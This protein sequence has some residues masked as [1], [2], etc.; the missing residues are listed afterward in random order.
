VDNEAK[1]CLDEIALDL[2]K[3]ADAKAVLVGEDTTKEKAPPKG[4]RHAPVA[5][6]AAQRAVNTKEYLVTEKGI[7][8]SRVSVATGTTDGQTVEDYLVPAGATFTGDVSGT[9]P[10]DETTVKPV[11]RKPLS[12]H[13]HRRAKA[14]E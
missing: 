1:A 8:A 11:A 4:R 5:D 10:V 2:Q 9:T 6:I 12:G 14:T 7:D 13:T 3:Q